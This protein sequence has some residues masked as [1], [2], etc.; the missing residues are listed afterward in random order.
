[1][2]E[3]VSDN[4]CMIIA[5]SG[6][7]KTE[8]V[9]K[10]AAGITRIY[11][12]G[13]NPFYVNTTQVREV[14]EHEVLPEVKGTVVEIFFYGAGCADE[15]SSRPVNDALSK[16]FP[17][18]SLQVA[19]DML[20]ASRGVCGNR[21]GLACILGTGANNSVYDGDNNIK[22]IGSLGFWLG[23]EGSGSYLGKTLLVRYLQNEL[24]DSIKALFG[25]QYP[26]VNRLSVLDRAY[27][28][29]FP[30]RYFAGFTHFLSENIEDDY[31]SELVRE[32]F[33]LFIEKYVVKHEESLKYPVHFVGSIAFYFREI[34]EK[35]LIAK[36]L[37][38][39]NIEKSP[40]DGL[41]RFHSA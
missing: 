37:K 5:D 13:L 23:D 40:M 30:N 14:L 12:M 38:V 19:S 21:P 3:K 7:T 10:G 1:M 17:D 39:G 25:T 34:L 35:C 41:I 20:G 16:V 33:D 4:S 2:I 18:A 9:I 27:K 6:S 28:Q 11:T 36:N 29:P 22:S 31:I 32:S 26:E 24:P 15:K 8:W